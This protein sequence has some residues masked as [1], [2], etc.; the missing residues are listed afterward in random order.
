VRHP[1]AV[2]RIP[3]PELMDEAE[4]A[5]A[6]S[7]ADFAEAHDRCVALCE[8]F[9]GRDGL[10]GTIL[11]LGCGPA[12]VTVRLARRF[13]RAVLHGVDGAE[14]MLAHGRARVA[15]EK[16]ADRIRLT[17]ALL[18]R[19]APPLEQYDG[20]VSNSLLHHLH[21]PAVLWGA[22]ARH[23]KPRAPVFVMDLRRPASI[24]DARRLRDT[25][26]GGEPDVLQRDFYNS[27]CAAFTPEEV[28]A[29]VRQAG[30]TL[31]VLTAGDRHLVARGHR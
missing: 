4:Q 7:E 30:L 22:V 12:D 13:P 23:A 2:N 31:E 15:R 10:T 8:D 6:Y 11:D 24:D 14:A 27:L 9:V 19:D 17:R 18:P 26:A 3:E 5:R 25:Y 1:D 21:D 20:V 28:R 16:L 29:Q